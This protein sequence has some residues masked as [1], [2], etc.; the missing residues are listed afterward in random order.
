[1][2]IGSHLLTGAIVS[3]FFD[4][5]VVKGA[6][7][8]GSIAPDISLVPIYLDKIRQTKSLNIFKF[9]SYIGDQDPFPPPKIWMNIYFAG[10]SFV[11][12]LFLW[13]AGYFHPLW[14]GFSAGYA[15]HLILDIPTHNGKWS[16]RPFYPLHPWALKG[17]GNWWEK[18]S[19]KKTLIPFWIL[20]LGI[21]F[22]LW[23]G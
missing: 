8:L 1:M 18:N 14:W 20:L 22:V 9:V 17:V 3:T 10:H 21:L 7:I 12:V 11:L 16:Q 6:C 5:P 13:G 4:S 19:M 2:D 15:S 23:K